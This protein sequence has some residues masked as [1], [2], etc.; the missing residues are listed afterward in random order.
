M[1][2][3]PECPM[4]ILIFYEIKRMNNK[5]EEER[6]MQNIYISLSSQRR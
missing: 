3:V 2:I 6:K 5:N 1:Y 4:L